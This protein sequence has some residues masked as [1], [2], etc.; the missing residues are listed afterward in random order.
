MQSML[1]EAN[2]SPLKEA[3]KAYDMLKRP[4]VTYDMVEQLIEPNDELPQIVREQVE[5]QI[6]YEGYIKKANEQVDKMLKMENKKYRITLIMMILMVLP[7]K[8][9]KN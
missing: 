5:I 8:Q 6:K 1:K 4:E 2:G 9:K 3:V 7:P